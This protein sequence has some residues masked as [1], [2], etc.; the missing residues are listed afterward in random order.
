M[1]KSTVL[2]T[3][4]FLSIFSL[5]QEEFNAN[6]SV[7]NF[8]DE[9]ISGMSVELI[10]VN[11]E[12]SR[13]G[14]TGNN[15]HF[16]TKLTTGKYIVKISQAGELLK[17]AVIEI[18]E[19]EGRQVYNNVTIQVLYEDRDVFALDDLHFDTNSAVIKEESYQLLDRL[20]EYLNSEQG[21]KFEIAGHTDSDGSDADNLNLSN[22]R[23]K[24]VR[25]YLIKRGVTANQLIAKG[26]GEKEPLVDNSTPEGRA[27]NRRTEI[28]R[29]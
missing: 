29:L 11:G 5:S 23:A 22:N 21:V 2:V 17:E 8:D 9:V 26:Y 24:A 25:E 18:P 13:K 27:M 1:K 14:T 28:R 10:N 12:I 20:V 6:I 3:L 15:G 4:M 16:S 7:T 19:L